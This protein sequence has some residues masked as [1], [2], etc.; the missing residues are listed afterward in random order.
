[1]D[2]IH[3]MKT[4][5]LTSIGSA[6]TCAIHGHLSYSDH[7]KFTKFIENEVQKWLLLQQNKT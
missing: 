2:F 5:Y 4:A 3:K 6:V 1:M 7:P